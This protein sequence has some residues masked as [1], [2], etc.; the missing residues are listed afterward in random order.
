MW[1]GGWVG[2]EVVRYLGGQLLLLL[3][4]LLEGRLD[5]VLGFEEEFGALGGPGTGGFVQ[6]K[7]GVDLER[8]EKVGGWVGDGLCR[9]E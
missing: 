2:G 1:V 9:D 8:E 3:L 5:L 6:A 4:A 7:E